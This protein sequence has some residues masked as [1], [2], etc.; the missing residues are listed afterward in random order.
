MNLVFIAIIIFLIVFLVKEFN[1]KR[2]L[3]NDIKEIN[4]KIEKII[5]SE[6]YERILHNT[7]NE[8]IK[9]LLRIVNKLFSLKFKEKNLRVEKEQNLQESLTNMAHDLRTPLT[10]I[11]G[12]IE[13]LAIENKEM[14]EKETLEKLQVKIK[15]VVSLMNRFFTLSKLES[16][17]EKI[18]LKPVNLT[19]VV[20]ENILSHYDSLSKEG[21]EVHINLS[22]E[23]LFINGNEDALNRVMNNIISNAMKYGSYGQYLAIT[24]EKINNEILLEITDKGQG[25]K[26]K[27]IKKIFDRCY[28]VKTSKDNYIEG[29]GIGLRITKVLVEAMGGVI[30]VKSKAYE[31]TTFTIKFIV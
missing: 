26:E 11:Q 23:S 4:S 25:I 7:D 2:L 15:E 8:E 6:E 5:D 21:F 30:E 27:E 3:K 22:E 16:G 12:Y 28:T 29:S 24:L 18:E 14:E 31:K 13:G 17:D 1:N 19:R 9:Q 10:I 20:R